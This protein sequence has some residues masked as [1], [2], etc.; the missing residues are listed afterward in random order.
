MKRLARWKKNE[1]IYSKTILRSQERGKMDCNSLNVSTV[2]SARYYSSIRLLNNSQIQRLRATNSLCLSLS[3]QRSSWKSH[4]A[5][6]LLA[7]SRI[8]R[9]VAGRQTKTSRNLVWKIIVGFPSRLGYSIIYFLVS[10]TLEVQSF[11]QAPLSL[12]QRLLWHS[13]AEQGDGI[14]PYF[15]LDP[16][17]NPLSVFQAFPRLL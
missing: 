8:R 11:G 17:S 2:G 14:H 3:R 12:L 9:G 13:R 7:R 4:F 10:A 16:R 15:S 1:Q 5:R 6:S